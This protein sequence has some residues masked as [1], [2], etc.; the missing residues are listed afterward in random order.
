MIKLT[1]TGNNHVFVE[2]TD[3][4][5]HGVVYRGSYH[6]HLYDGKNWEGTRDSNHPNT[7]PW[8]YPLNTH[9]ALSPVRQDANN[10][11]GSDRNVSRSA[12]KALA[13]RCLN[14]VV[15]A[16]KTRPQAFVQA[17]LERLKNEHQSKLE[18]L[19]KANDALNAASREEREAWDAYEAHRAQH[20]T[21]DEK[22][23]LRASAHEN[24]K[25]ES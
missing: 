25:T 24:Q 17:E 4:K 7:K 16:A 20:F 10:G 6:A 2:F 12:R 5:V 19:K 1:P 22:P 21:F 9:N 8:D 15:E 3:E 18:K 23:W 14:A 11:F 13:T